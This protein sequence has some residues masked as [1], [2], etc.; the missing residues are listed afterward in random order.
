M[1]SQ[2]DGGLLMTNT[3]FYIWCRREIAQESNSSV[4]HVLFWSLPHR[5]V[6]S[7]VLCLCSH[8]IL[9]HSDCLYRNIAN[10]CLLGRQI[11][12]AEQAIRISI[13]HVT[14]QDRTGEQNKKAHRQQSSSVIWDSNER[15][16]FTPKN[17]CYDHL[18]M[19]L[20]LRW[21]MGGLRREK[22]SAEGLRKRKGWGRGGAV[23]TDWKRLN[24]HD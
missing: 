15:D 22:G 13:E 14:L 1:S 9:C 10:K 16:P 7:S 18:P 11:Y 4:L 21:S 5:S 2:C 6:L 3:H 23:L 8:L 20:S 17:S 24:R 12:L 19:R